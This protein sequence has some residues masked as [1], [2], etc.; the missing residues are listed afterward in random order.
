MKRYFFLILAVLLSTVVLLTACQPN[1]S[2]EQAP[3]ISSYEGYSNIPDLGSI[4]GA[5]AFPYGLTGEVLLRPAAPSGYGSIPRRMAARSVPVKIVQKCAGLLQSRP[6]RFEIPSGMAPYGLALS[7]N[8]M[9]LG[10][11]GFGRSTGASDR[12][13]SGEVSAKP[14]GADNAVLAEVRVPEL[15]LDITAEVSPLSDPG[16]ETRQAEAESGSAPSGDAPGSASS[17]SGAAPDG[18]KQ[19]AGADG[20]GKEQNKTQGEAGEDPEMVSR[21][22]MEREIEKARDF[23]VTSFAKSLLAPLDAMEASLAHMGDDPALAAY[24]DGTIQIYRLFLKAFSDNGL[25]QIDPEK[26]SVFDP[27]T[28]EAIASVGGGD[29]SEIIIETKA[30]GY[31]LNGRCIRYAKVIV[32]SG[33]T[34]G[35]S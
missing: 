33:G 22:R 4:A 9:P 12:P 17:A 7:E 15:G 10:R 25:V 24:R 21:S 30:K 19:A 8:G 23:A 27:N 32:G 2:E 3:T 13:V 29:G 20:Q 26:G 16:Q 5:E 34:E 11:F 31:S 6:V 18:Q 35:G 1:G 28:E 14:A